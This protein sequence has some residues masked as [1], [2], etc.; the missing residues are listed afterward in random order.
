MIDDRIS[1]QPRKRTVF[2][3]NGEFEND[4]NET[5][6]SQPSRLSQLYK[7]ADYDTSGTNTQEINTKRIISAGTAALIS[8]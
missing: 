8:L 5:L 2:Q 4:R 1:D 3:K 7:K 6:Y